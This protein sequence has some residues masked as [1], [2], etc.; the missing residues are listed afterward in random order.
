[1]ADHEQAGQPGNRCRS[2]QAVGK[3]FR[4]NALSGWLGGHPVGG[5][6]YR[7]GRGRGGRGL[8]TGQNSGEQNRECTPAAGVCANP[9]YLSG[10]YHSR[11]AAVTKHA[12]RGGL[13]L[14]E[15]LITLVLIGMLCA[16][17]AA[18]LTA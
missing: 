13:A 17:V 1:M 2:A 8:G 14:I 6:V 9:T 12:G 3:S 4:V 11:E 18:A 7:P 15:V 16:V 5:K 10:P